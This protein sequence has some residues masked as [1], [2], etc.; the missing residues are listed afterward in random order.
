MYRHGDVIIGGPVPLPEGAKRKGDNIVV[1]GEV[2]GH[3]HRLAGG[4]IFLGG[5]DI[6]LATGNEAA[7]TH[8]DHE[9]I[10]LPTT[11]PGQGLLVTIQR[12]YDDESE[13]RKVT[14]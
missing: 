9:R 6:Y 7:L 4:T 1:A 2:T 11:K 8:E 13:W 3:A 10:A 14:D 12:E 5:S